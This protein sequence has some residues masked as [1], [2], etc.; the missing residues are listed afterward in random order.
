[1]T[2][3]AIFVLLIAFG[4]LAYFL[5]GFF[6]GQDIKGGF[7]RVFGFLTIP[8]MILLAPFWLIW[9][10]YKMSTHDEIAELEKNT[11]ELFEKEKAK[12]K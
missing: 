1:M 2:K 11:Q 7:K 5:S 8:V 3:E 12:H 9:A 10:I 4:V 6:V